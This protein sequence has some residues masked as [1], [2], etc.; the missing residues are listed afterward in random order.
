M[1]GYTIFIQPTGGARE[2]RVDVP[3]IAEAKAF[4]KWLH[5]ATGAA[6]GIYEM[7]TFKIHSKFGDFDES[8]V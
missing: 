4:A 6:V 3:F 1:K 7:R 2:H 5:E 8:R